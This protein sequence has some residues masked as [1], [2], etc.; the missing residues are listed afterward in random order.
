MGLVV[1]PTVGAVPLI[2]LR[3]GWQGAAD[4]YGWPT[5]EMVSRGE[6]INLFVSALLRQGKACVARA[7]A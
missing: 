1:A 6:P 4:F 7:D 3:A 5:G 2:D